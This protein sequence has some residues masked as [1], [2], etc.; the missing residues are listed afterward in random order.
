MYKT[1]EGYGITLPHNLYVIGT[2]NTADRSV[3]HL[4]YAI[5]RR[6][7]FIPV[8]AKDEVIT[9]TESRNLFNAIRN[10]V[11]TNISPEFASN[12]EDIQ[13]GHS[14]FLVEGKDLYYKTKY[15][16]IP[17]LKEY[18]NDGILLPSATDE[19]KDLLASSF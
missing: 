5:R 12:I 19:I 7:T 10:I 16:I 17:L 3:S 6:F 2:M 11:E 14:Y 1:K 4:D 9:N 13:I 15:E 18:I 8:L